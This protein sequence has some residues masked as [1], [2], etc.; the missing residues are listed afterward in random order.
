M[1]QEQKALDKSMASKE[2]SVWTMD[3]QAVLMCASIKAIALYYKTKLCERNMTYY[4][5]GTN[6]AYCYTYVE[7]QGDLS[8]NIFAQHFSD[9]I[10]K[11]PTINTAIIWSDGCGY[12]NKCAAV[13]NAFL[14][15]ASETKVCREHKYAAP[16]H[17]QMACDSVHR[18]IERRLVVDIFTPHDY[19]TVMQHSRPVP[20]PLCGN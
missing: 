12:Q 16:G 15:L 7:T 9:Y 11:D 20:F 14:K 3:L 4:N 8:S 19:A 18:T 5:L 13:S 17:T 10:T 1:A 2:N 6:E